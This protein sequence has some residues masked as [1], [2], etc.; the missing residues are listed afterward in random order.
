M[1][2]S[3]DPIRHINMY[4]AYLLGIS[5]EDDNIGLLFVPLDPFGQELLMVLQITIHI[6]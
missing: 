3:S 6:C 2:R 4:E 5:Y 1:H